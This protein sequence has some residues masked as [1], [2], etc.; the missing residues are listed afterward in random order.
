[1]F[2]RGSSTDVTFEHLRNHDN[3]EVLLI[4]RLIREI[5]RQ[6]SKLKL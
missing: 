3:I 1:M 2:L 4:K 6:V 5:S